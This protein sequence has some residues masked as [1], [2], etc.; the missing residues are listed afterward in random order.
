MQ[1]M[2]KILHYKGYNETIEYSKEDECFFGKV[3]N[4]QKDA[5]TYEGNYLEELRKNFEGAIEDYLIL[6][7]TNNER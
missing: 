2:Y 5:V 6:K 3:M 1:Y 4:L 7:A